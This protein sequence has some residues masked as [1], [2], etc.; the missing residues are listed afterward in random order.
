M[1]VRVRDGGRAELRREHDEIV[2]ARARDSALHRRF[3]ALPRSTP[4]RRRARK[5]AGWNVYRGRCRQLARP[6][7]GSLHTTP[8]ICS[9]PGRIAEEITARP[10]VATVDGGDRAGAGSNGL[11]G[12]EADGRVART[13]H[14]ELRLPSCPL[15]AR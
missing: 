12:F 13:D 8:S 7:S 2:R 1:P 14:I 4:A 9:V 6:R 15:E 3:Y 5:S 10:K 11:D